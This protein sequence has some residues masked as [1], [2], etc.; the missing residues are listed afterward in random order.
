MTD[1][2][3]VKI[4]I[5]DLHKAFGSKVVLDGVD[6]DI[7][8]AESLVIIGGSGTGKSVLLKHIIG[9]LKP[10]SGTVEVDGQAVEKLGNREITE[11]RRK[12]GMSFQEGAL[13]DSMTVWQNVA[14]PL[15][16]LTKMSHSEIGDRVEECLTMVRLEGVGEK[17]PSQLSG[18]MRRRVGFA[19]SVAHTPEILLFDEPTTGLDPVTTA[20][21]GEVILDL[22]DRLKTTTVTITHDMESAFLIGDRIAMLHQGKII[23]EAPPEEFQRL[24]DPRVQQFIHGKAEGP[25]SE[26]EVPTRRSREELETS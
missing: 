4:R 21:I 8:P 17:L 6:V 19:R 9:L 3:P 24:D 12:F 7:A 14:F 15:Q 26:E 23:A 25:L 13:F 1:S 20:L 10:D 11:F 16:R 5:R 22:S 18:G 2:K